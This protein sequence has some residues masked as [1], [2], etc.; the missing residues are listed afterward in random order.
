ML[1][2]V[3]VFCSKE[4][5]TGARTSVRLCVR[6]VSSPEAVSDEPQGSSNRA[7]TLDARAQAPRSAREL[8]EITS[9]F[10][11]SRLHR[12]HYLSPRAEQM[13]YL[14]LSRCQR[15]SQKS[16]RVITLCFWGV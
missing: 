16:M 12:A 2:V 1:P 11:L 8:L 7:V 6:L 3:R 15:L 14:A 13:V 4:P 10:R 9:F 5:H